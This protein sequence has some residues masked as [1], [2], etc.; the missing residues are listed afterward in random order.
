MPRLTLPFVHLNLRRNPFG[1]LGLAERA[2]LAQVDVRPWLPRLA[3][4]GFALHIRGEPGRGKTTHLLAFRRA[5]PEVPYIHIGYGPPPPIPTAPLLLLDETQRLPLK[6]RRRV[7]R[8]SC[9]LVLGTHT[10]HVRALERAGFT[11]ACLELG[12]RS[13]AELRVM[14]EARIEAARRAPGPLPRLTEQTLRRLIARHVDDIRGME[15]SLY[16]A[17]QALEEIGDVEV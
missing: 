5:L 7:F 17:F 1:E 6:L 8:P 15:S 14:F 10:D 3:R 2:A 12:E 11:V 9:S 4:P 16:D 13:P